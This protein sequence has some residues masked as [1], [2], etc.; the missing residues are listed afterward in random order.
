MLH[1]LRR[2]TERAVAGGRAVLTALPSPKYLSDSRRLLR[3]RLDTGA[4]VLDQ[5]TVTAAAR[6]R[7]AFG[8]LTADGEG[9][10]ARAWLAAASYLDAASGVF[11]E[12]SWFA[13][14]PT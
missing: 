11:A 13:E 3:A 2:A 10:F 4:M 8:R 7:D 14:P 9:V 5:L 12:S 1:L 6:P